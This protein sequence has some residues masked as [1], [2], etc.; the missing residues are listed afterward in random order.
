MAE[1][2]RVLLLLLQQAQPLELGD[3]ALARDVAILPGERPGLRGH[4]RV[5]A[6]DLDALGRLC[7]CPIS[8]SVGSC[9]GVTLTAPVPNAWSTAS[10]ATIG[11]R[12]SMIGRMR[13]AAHE[14]AVARVVR[15]DGDGGVA[16]DRLRARRRDGD[17][18]RVRLA[19]ERLQR[20][21]DVVERALRVLGLDFEVGDR[22][23]AD[24]DT[25]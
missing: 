10:S 17:V 22:A 2:D 11:M 8:K 1:R 23:H 6:D 24:A 12:R 3:D 5:E 14:V 21:A 13:V 9:A 19:G 20:V 7:R 18:A 16:Q 4:L 15:I 25:S